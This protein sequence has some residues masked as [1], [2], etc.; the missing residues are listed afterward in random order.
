MQ[1]TE[2][3][4]LGFENFN[5]YYVFFFL[6]SP[7][8]EAVCQRTSVIISPSF[9]SVGIFFVLVVFSPPAELMLHCC[10]SQLLFVGFS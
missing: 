5:Y 6:L 10:I 8:L 7:L 9:V 1:S 2:M 4:L 3:L